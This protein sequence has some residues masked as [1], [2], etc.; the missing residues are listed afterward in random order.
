MM[1]WYF[2]YNADIQSCCFIQ[3]VIHFNCKG[4]E[5]VWRRPWDPKKIWSVFY[6]SV[7][8]QHKI[9]NINNKTT[10]KKATWRFSIFGPPSCL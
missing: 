1:T 5:R 10:K 9:L 2:L 4:P 6:V 8:I 3:K 7:L